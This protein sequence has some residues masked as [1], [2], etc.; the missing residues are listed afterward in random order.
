[1]EDTMDNMMPG[2]N[3]GAEPAEHWPECRFNCEFWW[4]KFDLNNDEDECPNGHIHHDCSCEAAAESYYE[5][6]AQNQAETYYDR[7]LR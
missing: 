3:A 7:E 5:D 4:Y 2:S 6:V 1:M